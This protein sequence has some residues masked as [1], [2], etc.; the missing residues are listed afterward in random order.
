[1]YFKPPKTDS[2]KKSKIIPSPVTPVTLY[3]WVPNENAYFATITTGLEDVCCR[4]LLRK[5]NNV[6]IHARRG[7][8]VF[9]TPDEPS[10]V[11]IYSII[12]YII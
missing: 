3:E 8:V 10:K 5:L 7:K 1:M 12:N 4:E 11:L 2:N 9:S 6:R